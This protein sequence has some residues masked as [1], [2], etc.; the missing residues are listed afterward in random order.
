MCLG[1]D[2]ASDGLPG[3]DRVD[4]RDR[5]RRGWACSAADPSRTIAQRAGGLWGVGAVARCEQQQG[6]VARVEGA[7]VVAPLAR[8]GRLCF[9]DGRANRR[10]LQYKQYTACN[11]Y[12]TVRGAKASI[13]MAAPRCIG[14]VEWASRALPGWKGLS[15]R[16][17]ALAESEAYQRR[18]KVQHD[19]GPIDPPT[20]IYTSTSSAASSST[21]DGVRGDCTALR[22]SRRRRTAEDR[23]VKGSL[24][25]S[26]L[27]PSYTSSPAPPAPPAL[28]APAPTQ[29]R[30]AVSGRLLREGDV[31]GWSVQTSRHHRISAARPP[32]S[33]IRQGRPAAV[34]PAGLAG[35]RTVPVGAQHPVLAH[36]DLDA[37]L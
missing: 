32:H 37:R 17:E 26:V 6:R 5:D 11:V 13:R 18:R 3:W 33:S 19:P 23:I 34:E 2:L 35:E 31:R 8:G 28:P 30:A 10:N 36:G 24:C 22:E 29:L 15:R 21:C 27:W 4:K 14:P 20:T 1:H 7:S 16:W 9:G 25:Y 12:N